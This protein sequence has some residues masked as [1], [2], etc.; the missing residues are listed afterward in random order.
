MALPT[1]ERAP[2]SQ[3]ET[4]DLQ[5][6]ARY[7]AA[8][9][10]LYEGLAAITKA[11]PDFDPEHFLSGAKAAYEMIVTAFAQGDR[12]TLKN[13]LAPDV[14]QGFVAAIAEREKREQKAELTFVGIDEL[15]MTAAE[16]D[17][18]VSRDLAALRGRA[19]QLHARQGRQG[20]RGRPDRGADD[21]RR[22][23]IRARR[24]LARPELEARRDRS[25]L[26]SRFRAVP[27]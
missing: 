11:D 2:T 16:L 6:L 12:E 18:K 13:L 27:A 20:D 23:D 7:A 1:R 22:V 17:G 25:G 24:Q 10:P 3:S 14:F 4:P 5:P 19:H 8:G 9:T 15:K 21:P 26:T